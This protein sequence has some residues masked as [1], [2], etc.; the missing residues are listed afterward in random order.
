VP[1]AVQA[2]GH[3]NYVPADGAL[4]IRTSRMAG[5]LIDPDRRIAR[6]GP[7]TRW[8]EVIDAAAPLGLAPLSGSSPDVGVAGYTLGGGLGWLS[9]RH[10]FAADSLLRAGLVT[11]DGRLVTASRDRHPDLFWALRGGGGNFGVVTSLEFRLYP[12]ATVYAGIA[13]FPWER[14]ADTLA[15][16]REWSALEPAALTTAVI[17][18]AEPPDPA[19]PGPALAIRALYL[20]TADDARRA[21]RPLWDAAGPPARDEMREMR[22]AQTRS[23]PA[24]APRNFELAG[25][26]PD[27]LIGD[28][29]RAVDLAG[30]TGTAAVEVR[31]WGGA[32][33][34]AGPDAGPV[35]HRD[36]P[37]SVIVNGPPEAAAPVRS[38]ATGGSF[39]NFLHDPDRTP[40]AYTPA[41][42]RRLRDVKR[43]WDP[44]NVFGLGHNIPPAAQEERSAA[45]GRA[46]AGERAATRLRAG[47]GGWR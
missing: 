20:G 5:V 4:L 44:D 35:G 9:R 22:F 32:M 15:R 12:A 34:H 6:V 19:V 1:V 30:Q 2:T 38:Y 45:G 23:I 3:G 17:L 7:G 46:A 37:F 39:L 31:H 18:V 47:R 13:Y 41:D 10:G 14:A 21:L 8:S 42:Y 24:V 40:T 43:A 26:L 36:V 33:A 25:R 16:Y 11:A 28:L 29:I 27:P